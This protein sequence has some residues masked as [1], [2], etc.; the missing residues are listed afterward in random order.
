MVEER[1]GPGA[2]RPSRLARLTGRPE[3]TRNLHVAEAA[4]LLNPMRKGIAVSCWAYG[5]GVLLLMLSPAGPAS[6]V[7]AAYMGVIGAVSVVLGFLWWRGGWPKAHVSVAFLLYS[8]LS[9]TGVLLFTTSSMLA[10]IAT[11]WFALIGEHITIAHSRRAVGLHALW[12]LA[13]IAFFAT[14]ASRRTNASLPLIVYVGLALIGLIVA[15]PI[16]RQLAADALRDDSRRAA[17]L[18]ERDALTALLNHRGMYA[19]LP[20]LLAAGRGPDEQLA[21]VVLDL[22]RFKAINDRYGHHRGDQVLTLVAARL[23]GSVRRGAIVARTGG[24]EFIVIDTVAPD[25]AAALAH[26]LL[27]AVHRQD[28]DVPVTASVGVSSVPVRDVPVDRLTQNV[29][30]LI[31]LSDTTMYGAKRDGGNQVRVSDPRTAD[32]RSGSQ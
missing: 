7:A 21:I 4:S 14:Q 2:S 25:G 24:E 6:T 13:N 8:E 19:A 23:T 32:R 11:L 20:A 26:R 18:A 9:H 28:D 31:R 17:A 12:A 5:L 10:L 1:D 16:F 29:Q 15:I 30:E 3:Y 22:D 27:R